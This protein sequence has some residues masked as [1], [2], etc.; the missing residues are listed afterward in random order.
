VT[1]SSRPRRGV[2]LAG[3]LALVLCAGIVVILVLAQ[4][5]NPLPIA[6]AIARLEVT[7]VDIAPLEADSTRLVQ[8]AGTE[9][10]LTDYLAGYGWTFTDRLGSGIVYEKAGERLFVRARPLTRWYTVY[11]LE[12][13]P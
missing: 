13:P 6:W 10:P 1:R 9:G 12:A 3:A 4:A 7:G 8:R 5:G 2:V 11:E